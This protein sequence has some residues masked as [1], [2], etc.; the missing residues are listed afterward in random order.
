MN[1]LNVYKGP[2]AIR[3]YYDPNASPPL[4]LVEIP[5]RLNPY[6]GH[7][8]RIYAKMMSMHPANNVKAIPAL[9]LLAEAIEPGKTETVVE[10]SSGSTVLSMSLI[11]RALYG[12]ADVRAFL[13]NKTSLAKIRLMQLFGIDITLFGGPSQPEPVDERGGIRAAQRMAQE[14]AS[15]VNPNQYGND[16]NW[17]A[18]VKWTGPQILKQ[19]P[20]INVICAGMGTSGTMTGLGTYFQ[21]AKPSVFRL[22]VCT[23]PGDRVPGPRSY[24]LL[25]PVEFP[26]RK[27]VDEIVEMGSH[28]SFAL[29][30][31]LIR[32]G[33]VCGPS[34]GFNLAGLFR[35]IEKRKALDTLQTLAGPDGDIHCVFLCCDLP[36]PY[37]NEYFDKLGDSYFGPIHNE[38]LLGVDSYRYDEKWERKASDAL[39][40]F[41]QIP[42]TADDMLGLASDSK[43][44]SLIHPKPDTVVVDLRQ[45]VDFAIFHLPSSVNIPIVESD[46]ISP[47]FDPQILR[48]LWLRLEDTFKTPEPALRSLLEGKRILLLCYDGDSAR[49]CASVLRAKG[50][51]ADSVR[52]GFGALEAL[53]GEQAGWSKPKTE[54]ARV[55]AKDDSCLVM[56]NAR[57]LRQLPTRLS[58]R[59]RVNAARTYSSKHYI[60]TSTPRPGVGQVTLLRPK[61]LNALCTPLV[62]ELN[63]ALN[64]LNG[65]DDV[66]VIVLT[67]SQKAFAAGA[68]IK[69]MAPLTFSEAYTKSFIESWSLLTT[70]VKKPV[71]AAVSGYALGGGCELAMMCDIIYC[72]EDANF[73]QPEVKL[74][75]TPGAGGSQR[76]TRAIGKAKAMEL[77]LSGRSFTGV[78]AERWGVAARAFPSYEALMEETYKLAETIAGYSRVAVMACKEV[79]NK[80]QDLSLRD[81]V[82]FERRVFHSLFGSRDQ[83]KGMEAFAN[84]QKAE[85]THS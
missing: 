18:H 12:V 17:Q 59:L 21:Q 60:D 73:G 15:T 11:A 83:K 52:G 32:H 14:S 36:Y 57:I 16:G 67:G 46:R 27:A 48:S 54:T 51:E 56:M 42:K 70:L 69:E 63:Q 81:G 25:A 37:V 68:D 34:S 61:A 58:P 78:E 20:E 74:G 33:I 65:S 29:S 44:D 7:G 2:D 80:S 76:L 53:S 13:S 38:E 24:A 82:E 49:V 40:D 22:G 5:D 8:V 50:Y 35:F 19:L 45:A 64:H 26:W 47:F 75:T 9:N 39:E 79:V 62:N 28:D 31:D 6:R 41:Y 3:D 30:L 77:I 85:W 23:A 10:Y 4:P 71:I 1:S 72:T 66:S 43:Q 55:A 84:K